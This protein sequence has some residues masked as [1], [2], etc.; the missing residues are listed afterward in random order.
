MKTVKAD[1]VILGGG[2]V[3]TWLTKV[4]L[5][6]GKKVAVIEIGPLDHKNISEPKPDLIFEDREHIGALKARNQVFTGNSKFWGGALIS[7]DK[8]NIAAMLNADYNLEEYYKQVEKRLGI[9]IPGRDQLNAGKNADAVVSSAL[10]LA[11]KDRDIWNNFYRA[12]KSNENLNLFTESKIIS[13]RHDGHSRKLKSIKIRTADSED[14]EIIALNYILTMGVIDSNIFAQAHIANIYKNQENEFGTGL[15]DHWS[16]PIGSFK[17]HQ[18]SELKIIYPPAFNKGNIIG[19]RIEIKSRTKFSAI[20]FIHVQANYDETPPYSILKNLLFASQKNLSGVERADMAFNLL[21]YS[22]DLL[23]IAYRRVIENRLYIPEGTQLNIVLDF[24]SFPDQ[25]NKIV[26]NDKAHLF[27]DIRD[28][29]LETFYDLYNEAKTVIAGLT[30]NGGEKYNL[31]NSNDLDNH[32]KTNAI[33]AY[34]LG[35]GL[36]IDEILDRDLR[37]KEINNF[38]VI[39]TAVFKR[40]GVANPVFTLLALAEKYLSTIN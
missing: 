35:G 11:G 4:L 12:N 18:N 40:S 25:Q 17:W 2:I 10:V 31:V 13:F 9:S 23:K 5:Q 32:I 21:K 36:K 16:V 7:N 14:I 38:A 20:G 28:E 29:D 39:S 27:W 37:F 3:G 26:L 33:D 6:K 34:H 1:I 15:H 19:K 8:D 30:K 22:P 24:E